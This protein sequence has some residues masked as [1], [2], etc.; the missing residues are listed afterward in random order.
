MYFYCEH[1]YRTSYQKISSVTYLRFKY[2]LGAYDFSS[3]VLFPPNDH[4]VA[5][6]PSTAPLNTNIHP[7]LHV[8]RYDDFDSLWKQ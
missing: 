3:K 7:H 2:K 5:Q 6:K 4:G 1:I 8:V